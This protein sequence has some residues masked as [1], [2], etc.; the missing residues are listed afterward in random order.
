ML[1]LVSWSDLAAPRTD[2]ERGRGQE[3]AAGG[4]V[5]AAGRDR[6][7]VATDDVNYC[8]SSTTD[9]LGQV[10]PPFQASVSPP[11]KWR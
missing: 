3:Q 4:E 11:T 8:F 5:I 10:L 1:A 9:L 7:R 2:Q 6:L